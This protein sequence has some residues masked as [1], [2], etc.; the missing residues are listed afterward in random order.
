M[1]EFVW[2]G[3]CAG[4]DAASA[5]VGSGVPASF[6]QWLGIGGGIALHEAFW[7]L[8]VGVSDPH[9]VQHPRW[10]AVRLWRQVSWSPEISH[11]IPLRVFQ[12]VKVDRWDCSVFWCA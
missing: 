7:R 5:P 8:V 3:H 4:I 1:C 10:V 11:V 6:A 12:T 9:V 2:G